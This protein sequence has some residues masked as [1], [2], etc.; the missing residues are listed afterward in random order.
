MSTGSIHNVLYIATT[1]QRVWDALTNPDVTERYWFG[2][3]M[4]SDW[5]V[6][7]TLSYVVRG[8]T[9]DEQTI[10]ASDP[11]HRLAYT[12]HPLAEPF[13][14][15]APSRVEFTIDER[16][17]VVRLTV[18]HDGFPP[19]SAVLPACT[20]AWPKILSGLKSLLETGRSLPA[21]EFAD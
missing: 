7:S 3:R 11:P 8:R 19:G 5:R 14:R 17:G 21:L 12:F 16:D 9:T 15:E 20:G 18:L 4:E 1:T 6:G 13:V 2:T 10:V